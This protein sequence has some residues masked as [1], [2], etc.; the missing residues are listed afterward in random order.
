MGEVSSLELPLQCR[1]EVT[2]IGGGW[3]SGDREKRVDSRGIRE[4]EP[5]GLGWIWM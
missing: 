3:G 5:T 4:A 2:V 1:Q